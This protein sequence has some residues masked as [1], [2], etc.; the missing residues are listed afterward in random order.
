MDFDDND[1]GSQNLHLAG[2]ENSKISSVLRPFSL[3]KFDFDDSLH[4]HLRFDSLV[5]N[6]VFLGIPSQ[7]DN[8]WIEDFSRGSSG[9]EFSS[10][11][12]EPCALPRHDNVWSEATS[13]ESVEMLLK[14]VGQEEV[15]PGE[16]MVEGSDPQLG[17]S[18][19]QVEV[20]LENDQMDYMRDG[21][22]CSLNVTS[23]NL[24]TDL[25]SSMDNQGD[26]SGLPNESFSKHKQENLP[27]PSTVVDNESFSRVITESV[28]ETGDVDKFCNPN[29]LNTVSVVKIFSVG[30]EVQK[31]ECSTSYEL[32]G[33]NDAEGISLDMPSHIDIPAK[34]KSEDHVVDARVTTTGETSDIS[35]MGEPVSTFEGFNEASFVAEGDNDC[36]P[37]VFSSGTKITQLPEGC[38]MLTEKPSSPLQEQEPVEGIGLEDS[39]RD[40]PNDSEDITFDG[41]VSLERTVI[42]DITNVK[43]V[44]AIE[45]ENLEHGDHVPPAL[46]PGSI[47]S[48]RENVL[49]LQLDVR[50]SELD[51]SKHEQDD[52]K[53][54][55]DSMMLV[56]DDNEK[57]GRSII[58]SEVV[59][60]NLNTASSQSNNSTE[61]NPVFNS[62]VSDTTPLSSDVIRV[63]D[64]DERGTPS[65]TQNR[66]QINFEANREPII[67][68]TEV[69]GVAEEFAPAIGS[70]KGNLSDSGTV[71]EAKTVDQPAILMGGSTAASS[72][73]AHRDL[74]E[75][76]EDSA[77]GLTVQDD[78]AEAALFEKPKVA[79]EGRSTG[80]NFSIAASIN[81][82]NVDKSYQLSRPDIS[83]TDL[84]QGKVSKPGNLKNSGT[85]NVGNVLSSYVDPKLK[86][87]STEEGIST[88]AIRHLVS[89][90]KSTGDSNTGLQSVPSIQP[91][92]LPVTGNVSTPTSGGTD[93]A[94]FKGISLENSLISDGVLPSGVSHGSTE[95][96]SRRGSSKS[97]KESAKKGNQSKEKS[98]LRQTERGDKS[99]GP[100]SP[101]LAGQLMTLESVVRPRATV[102]ITGSSLPDLNTS[103]PLSAFFQQPFTD[104]Q[105]V[106]LR[107]Q[108]FVYGSLIQGVAPDEACMVSAFGVS[109]GGRSIW[110]P[111]WRAVVE[112]LNGQNSQGFNFDT[113]V[114]SSSG[115]KAPDQVNRLTSTGSEVLL[116]PAGRVSNKIISSQAVNPLIP[117]SSPLWNISVS[118][119]EAMPSSST[120]RC[121]GFDFPAVSP[122]STSWQ[123]QAPYPVPWSTSSQS[124]PFDI[125]SN[126]NVF[127]ISEPVK[128]TAAVKGPSS[129][130]SGTKHVSPI[131][132]IHTGST[133]I[134]PE[135]SSVDL[136]KVSLPTIQTSANPKSRKRKKS[137]GVDAVLLAPVTATPAESFSIPLMD[138]RLSKK[139]S[140]I[141]DFSRSMPVG[142]SHYSTSIAFTTPSNTAPKGKSI[143]FISAAW[144]AIYS[145]HL[146][147]ADSSMD[148]RAPVLEEF[149][150]VEEAKL[151]AEE[152]AMHAAAAVRHCQG[153]W[154]Q[155]EHQKNSGLKTE[156]EAKLASAAAAVAAA[157]S[158]A[159]AAAAAAKVASNAAMQ[160]KQ[161]A[162]ES[163][164]NCGNISAPECNTL[165]SVNNLAHAIPVSILTGGDYNNNSSF[166][167]SAAKEAARKRVEAASVA[168]RHAENLDAIVKAAEMA[169]E[170]V[171]HAGKV[172]A[173]GDPLTLSQLVEAGP[174]GYWKVSQ[175][176]SMP[177]SNLND[178]NNNKSDNSNAA[179]MYANDMHATS[180]IASPAQREL[181]KN[182]VDTGVTVEEGLVSSIKHGEKNSKAHKDKRVT[183]SD[184]A[185]IIAA[186]PLI[187]SG[188]KFFTPVTY[189][190]TAIIKEGSIIEV[191][192]DRG[193]LKKAWF[194]ANV[195]SLKDHDAF[196]CFTD[197]QSEGSEQ[198]KEWVSLE[199][200]DGNPPVSRIPH[201]MS[202]LQFEGTRKRRRAAVKD[203]AWSVGDK[204]DAWVRDG[205]CEGI[206]SEK[207][208]KDATTW[209]VHFPAQGE[210]LDVK[211][212]HLRPTVIWVDDQ[213][214]EWS[215][216]GQDRTSQGDTPTDKRPKLGHTE[217]ETKGKGELSKVIDFAEVDKAEHRL[218]LSA[219][220]TAFNVGSSR[221]GKK[222][223]MG[224]TMR[225]GSQKVG[226]RVVIGVPK[227]GKKRKF[228][229]VSKHYVSDRSTKT[230]PDDSVKLAKFLPS[231]G[232]GFRVSKNNS[233]IDLKDKL[234]AEAKSKAPKSGKP[235]TI[236]NRIVPRKDGVTPSHSSDA[237]LSNDDNEPVERSLTEFESFSNVPESSI[238]FSSRAQS[239][240]RKKT[241]AM[242][243]MSER[244]KKGKLA[245][246]SGKSEKNEADE[247]FVSGFAEPR[248]SIRRIQP[249]SRLL[250]GLQSSLTISK[251]PSSSHDKS[252]RSHTKT[253]SKGNI[254]RLVF[255][256]D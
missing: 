211:V 123:A 177:G 110:E 147:S 248:R 209:S 74:N 245:P 71:K 27:V 18:M 204:V 59:E 229:E 26:S 162:D 208:K 78:V 90:T 246:R 175:A 95:R 89:Q 134:F 127:P 130:S 66:G 159:K 179:V 138:N 11:A 69:S 150:K 193:D 114:R 171:S 39:R 14:A 180:Q 33:G 218:P 92:I 58:S 243:T 255:T 194:S 188:S 84:S 168:T 112:K 167:I 46:V 235:P 44:A 93:P 116:S 126:Y 29:L 240:N 129:I 63:A 202:A 254:E 104:L 224:R 50:E 16:T 47:Q 143:P 189:D 106:Q 128:P 217:M 249:T 19:K 215:R 73:K 125:S 256:A 75:K 203:Y 155:L 205:W 42:E 34:L 7:E 32:G 253:S 238:V 118:P 62:G 4:G 223:D 165:N 109:D 113:P 80:E 206:I 88:S 30:V 49:S 190:S 31:E 170:A 200:K 166:V 178:V 51:A 136:K 120:S 83:C 10:N 251:L 141:E 103:T 151:H 252:H 36:G 192:K 172:V 201:P 163:I 216:P 115:A 237:A 213:W 64:C 102:S 184:K 146:K 236:P 212:W 169:A 207:N 142:S 186:E 225:S 41:V 40:G 230:V 133:G 67:S 87:L 57:E 241:S 61:D 76:M 148:K 139:S 158:V 37:A 196:V 117:L 24:L 195:L 98:S 181:S 105:Q 157:A 199:A 107:A 81:A 17:S 144:P 91:S 6:E 86:T 191:L 122:W 221:D 247:I 187:K 140:A 15:T 5:E 38:N 198:L 161:I 20:N 156:A 160:A 43:E 220:E 226:S 234:V 119:S 182:V 242:N 154:S 79:E 214:I 28:V 56:C 108:I 250:E 228:I 65:D 45:E 149:G 174:D 70:E 239:E 3:P 25:K 131:P 137:S 12:T 111:S 135:A 153:L 96:K 232:P 197:L 99:C 52:K 210:T 145:D 55:L 13:S 227:P 35:R 48:C 9:I 94:I 2:E 132:Q 77:P 183:E 233:K 85:K 82:V 121:A 1:C 60:V 244:L 164:T 21:E 185:S 176:A 97:V 23:G 54:P 68:E 22:G 8:H 222:P 173:M 72:D 53:L 101:L 219:E 152:A 124:S 100:L 231:Q